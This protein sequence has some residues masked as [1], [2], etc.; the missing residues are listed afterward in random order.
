MNFIIPLVIYPFDIMVSIDESDKQL[1][2][3][4]KKFGIKKNLLG[5]ISM[6]K[7][8]SGK[9][10]MFESNRTLIR[11]KRGNDKNLFISKIA[12]ESL[13]AVSFIFQVIGIKLTDESE[14]AYTYLLD[15][16]ILQILNR[17]K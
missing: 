7:T 3:E 14:E 13:H 4:L 12:H 1:A 8:G 9:C 6:P 15:Y 2:E 5:A 17:I 11:L 16:I 10:I